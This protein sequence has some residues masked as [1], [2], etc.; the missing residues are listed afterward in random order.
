MTWERGRT[1]TE[2][3]SLPKR[4]PGHLTLDFKKRWC[5]TDKTLSTSGASVCKT[6][7]GVS[8]RCETN[9]IT[10]HSA[11]LP[12]ETNPIRPAGVPHYYSVDQQIP[13]LPCTGEE[14]G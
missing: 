2:L 1:E 14:V 12:D 6:L 3:Q 8:E 11:T 4:N 13:P 5:V 7:D 10:N 9:P